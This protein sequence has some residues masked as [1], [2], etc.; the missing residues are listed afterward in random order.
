MPCLAAVRRAD[1]LRATPRG[2]RETG[3]LLRDGS[4]HRSCWIGQ[5]GTR[6]FGITEDVVIHGDSGGGLVL[7]RTPRPSRCASLGNQ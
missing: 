7:T 4:A 1:T 2:R 6:R 3:T 5:T